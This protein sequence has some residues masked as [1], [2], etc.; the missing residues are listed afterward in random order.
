M[1]LTVAVTRTRMNRV[2]EDLAGQ[3]LGWDQVV[4]EISEAANKGLG[5]VVFGPPPGVSIKATDA[6]AEAEKKLTAAGFRIEWRER[7][8]P[9]D[10]LTHELTVTWDGA[11][12]AA[13]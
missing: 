12:L 7:R 13:D 9:G 2:R 3:V 1:S 10:V 11:A 6:A 4:K 5:S 8:D